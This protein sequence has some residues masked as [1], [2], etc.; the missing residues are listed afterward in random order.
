M[1]PSTIPSRLASQGDVRPGDRTH[2]CL[3]PSGYTVAVGACF[4]PSL[5]GFV[6]LGGTGAQQRLAVGESSCEVTQKCC[7]DGRM[8]A[9]RI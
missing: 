5:K 4:P 7:C 1:L 2:S 8:M 9:P 3:P 6:G